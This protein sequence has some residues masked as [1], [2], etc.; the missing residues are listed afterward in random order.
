MEDFEVSE[1]RTELSGYLAIILVV[2]LLVT[3]SQRPKRQKL[4]PGIPIVGASDVQY[5]K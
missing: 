5:V 4:A 2:L 1:K 3:A